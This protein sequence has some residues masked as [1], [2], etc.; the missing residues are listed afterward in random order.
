MQQT[1]RE[2]TP[3]SAGP[4]MCVV[5]MYSH[6]SGAGNNI[7]LA[8]P[9]ALVHAEQTHTSRTAGP[10]S[11]VP[12]LEA[13]Y[14]LGLQLGQKR[15]R[16]HPC[17]SDFLFRGGVRKTRSA[18]DELRPVGAGMRVRQYHWYTLKVV[19]TQTAVA[20]TREQTK[21][22]KSEVLGAPIA[23]TFDPQVR[24]SL[25]ASFQRSYNVMHTP[26]APETV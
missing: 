19:A 16:R 4:G 26:I 14:A 6:Q 17:W 3:F 5:C 18:R 7:R 15:G 11:P 8:P 24:Y 21:R 23:S 12:L 2:S 10:C 9:H 1:A 25:C 13:S 22:K 20:T